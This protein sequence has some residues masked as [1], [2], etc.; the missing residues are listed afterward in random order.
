MSLLKVMVGLQRADWRRAKSTSF[1]L[2][3]RTELV[4][5]NRAN[6]PRLSHP[7]RKPVCRLERFALFFDTLQFLMATVHTGVEVCQQV[8]ATQNT[9]STATKSWRRHFVDFDFDVSVD[10][11]L[12]L[13]R[14][15]T[16]LGSIKAAGFH[17]CYL[18]NY[19][20][21]RYCC[22]TLLKYKQNQLFL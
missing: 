20:H 22:T 2:K 9:K 13:S 16:K 6:R 21:C 18:S 3:L 11:P 15:Q 17:T 5:E 19:F 12:D 4:L 14:S 10:E 1:V 7:R 8:L